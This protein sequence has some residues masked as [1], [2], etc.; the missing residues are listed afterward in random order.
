[1]VIKQ[2]VQ[3]HAVRVRRQKGWVWTTGAHPRAGPLSCH[4]DHPSINWEKHPFNWLISLKNIKSEILSKPLSLTCY[5]FLITNSCVC[6]A[7]S[8]IGRHSLMLLVASNTC[9]FSINRADFFLKPKVI[10][11][12]FHF[13]KRA[14]KETSGLKRNTQ[15]AAQAGCGSLIFCFSLWRRGNNPT[16]F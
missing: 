14:R 7:Q 8:L 11:Y 15:S 5:S 4:M 12:V 16:A 1:M 10:K 2:C 13:S 9:T 6:S 3:D